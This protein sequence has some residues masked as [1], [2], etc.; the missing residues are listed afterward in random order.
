MH[1]VRIERRETLA[2]GSA[3]GF[4]VAVGANGFPIVGFSLAGASTTTVQLVVCDDA[5]CESGSNPLT[6]DTMDGVSKVALGVDASGLPQVAYV[7]L[8]LGGNSTRTLKVASCDEP[9]CSGST[10]IEPLDIGPEFELDGGSARSV[11]M[12]IPDMAPPL[13]VVKAGTLGGS[14]IV[15]IACT[16]DVCDNVAEPEEVGQLPSYFD[17]ID[18]ALSAD[19]LPMIVADGASS[20][21]ELEF[22][23]CQ[24]PNC[25]GDKTVRRYANSRV[26]SGQ[27]PGV[28]AAAD[29]NPIIGFFQGTS[30]KRLRHTLLPR[31]RSAKSRLAIEFA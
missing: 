12:L 10:V 14:R 27:L 25:A 3:S 17:E 30:Q 20:G 21:V 13:V 5:A 9:D 22:I 15:S 8:D 28:A 26:G 24:N 29:G 2:S 4:D 11:S 1:P 6:V 7:D 31:P 23:Q 19:G 18:V 16:T